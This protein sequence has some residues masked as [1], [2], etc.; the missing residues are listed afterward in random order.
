LVVDAQVRDLKAQIRT[1]LPHG[2]CRILDA[3][4]PRAMRVR[5]C[6]APRARILSEENIM[7]RD[8]S[9]P[10]RIA[11]VVSFCFAA[12]VNAQTSNNAGGKAYTHD[13][14]NVTAAATATTGSM[15]SKAS[16]ISSGDRKFME[17]AAE[18]G[19]AEVKLGELATQKAQ[20]NQVKQFGQR[21]VDDH[22][23]ANEQ[24]KQL[25]STKGVTLPTQLDKS[26]Q[27]EYDK[28]SKLSGAGFDREYM[29]HMV[30]DHKKDVGEFKSEANKAKDAD[31]KQFASSTLPTLEEH[32]QLAQSAEQAAKNEGKTQTSSRATAKTGS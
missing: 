11:G 6:R 25:A 22:G 8:F 4:V 32:L 20:A 10:A 7:S 28:L 15:N 14:P 26:T 13:A 12:A 27:R 17:K 9:L 5:R 16:T 18:G 31:V 3:R 29:K 24:L 2:Y 30:S 1:R 21:M 23:K 19:M